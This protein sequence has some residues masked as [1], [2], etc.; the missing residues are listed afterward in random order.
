MIGRELLRFCR[1][2]PL[3]RTPYLA[4]SIERIS[5]AESIVA[6]GHARAAFHHGY[7]EVYWAL[8]KRAYDARNH[9]VQIGLDPVNPDKVGTR[10]YMSPGGMAKDAEVLLRIASKPTDMIDPKAWAVYALP[11]LVSRAIS[12]MGNV[13]VLP[14]DVIATIGWRLTDYRVVGLA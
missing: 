5:E 14:A 9:W 1:F 3:L 4:P 11:Q 6:E 10:V 2:K 13:S 12:E 8:G 7:G